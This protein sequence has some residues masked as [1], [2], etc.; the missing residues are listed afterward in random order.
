VSALFPALSGSVSGRRAT[1][2]GFLFLDFT[3]CCTVSFGRGNALVLR[4]VLSRPSLGVLFLLRSCGRNT[5]CKRRGASYFFLGQL[6]LATPFSS[7]DFSPPAFPL[8]SRPL[9][10]LSPSKERVLRRILDRTVF[11]LWQ[12]TQV[13]RPPLC[14]PL[15]ALPPRQ[16][17]DFLGSHLQTHVLFP[18]QLK[19]SQAK[20]DTVSALF[21]TTVRHCR[22]RIHQSPTSS[23]NLEPRFFPVGHSRFSDFAPNLTDPRRPRLFDP[24]GHEFSTSGFSDNFVLSTLHF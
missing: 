23:N 10:L 21:A 5:R 17:Q 24:A 8:L 18:P 3:L 16:D 7:S 15:H 1:G 2:S 14:T 11:P 12:A 13:S 9:W 4:F 19:L 22:F 20:S 6:G